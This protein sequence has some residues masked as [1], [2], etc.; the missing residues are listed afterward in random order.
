MSLAHVLWM[1]CHFCIKVIIHWITTKYAASRMKMP[2][3]WDWAISVHCCHWASATEMFVIALRQ[4]AKVLIQLAR[5][6]DA[7]LRWGP[8]Q[9]CCSGLQQTMKLQAVFTRQSTKCQDSMKA[10]RIRSNSRSCPY[11]RPPKLFSI[12][13]VVLLT[14]HWNQVTLNGFQ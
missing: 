5:R 13:N 8:K 9:M 12:W 6:S 10:Y 4:I 3:I 1:D 2:R 7:T 11:N 14:A